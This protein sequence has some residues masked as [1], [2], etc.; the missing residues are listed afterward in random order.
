MSVF[1]NLHFLQNLIY[2]FLE[3]LI[4]NCTNFGCVKKEKLHGLR[5]SH[6]NRTFF[7]WHVGL[8]MKITCFL[9]SDYENRI[10]LLCF[11]FFY[12]NYMVVFVLKIAKIAWFLYAIIQKLHKNW[13]IF[14]YRDLNKI[15][16]NFF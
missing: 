13:T 10:V 16:S 12:K 9:N 8:I 1:F 5:N 7:E 15:F 2:P 3:I 4:K 6:K 11:S 14:F